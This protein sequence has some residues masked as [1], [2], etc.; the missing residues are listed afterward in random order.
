MRRK[1]VQGEADK[2]DELG[3]SGDLDR[4]QAVTALI[5]SDLDAISKGIRLR[6]VESAGE[7]LHHHRVGVDARK[8]LLV[9]GPPP[10]QDQPVGVEVGRGGCGAAH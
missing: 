8:G 10:A 2:A 9:S 6:S 7:M 1:V 5:E 3:L 4:P